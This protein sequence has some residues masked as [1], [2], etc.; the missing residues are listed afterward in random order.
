M[1]TVE[2]WDVGVE[3]PVPELNAPTLKG[4]VGSFLTGGAIRRKGK[5]V[6]VTALEGVTLALRPGDRV[7]LVG[8]NGAGKSTLLRVLSGLLPP[9]AGRVRIEGV[10]SPLLSIHQGM[11]ERATGRQN[12]W[13]RARFMGISD[14]AIAE[15][16]GEVA[17]FSELGDYLELPLKTY[18][19]GMRLRLAFS[20]ATAFEPEILIMDEWIA[21]GDGP[22]RRKAY[23]R[24][25][26]L[27]G[28]SAIFAFASQTL[29]LQRQLCSLGI[30]LNRGSVLFS[31]PIA[32]ALEVARAYDLVDP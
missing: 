5:R 31:G 19:T 13:T 1:A 23:D 27:V 26:G 28:R 3:Y 29:A 9:T 22:F 30:V 24:L 21:V 2:L 14:D 18:S 8:R 10:V 4:A 11:D 17:A 20:I 32:D 12:I 15:R 6:S 7:G 25:S 16:L